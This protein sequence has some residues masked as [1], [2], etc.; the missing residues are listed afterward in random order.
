MGAKLRWRI[1]QIAVLVLI[2]AG[3]A[4][5]QSAGDQF[6]PDAPVPNLPEG[7]GSPRSSSGDA[8]PSPLPVSSRLSAHQKYALAFRR[9][10][11]PQMPLRAAFVSGW[12]LGTDTGP[13]MPTNGWGPFVERFGYNAAAIS[14]TIFFSTAFVPAIVHQDPR[15]FRMGRGRVKSRIWWAVRSE[16]V[17]VGDDGH[18][19][20]NYAN[21]LGFALSSAAI[22]TFT[23]RDSAGFGDTVERYAIKI[24]VSTGLNVAREFTAFD[25]AKDLLRHSKIYH[26]AR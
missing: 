20:P 16:I 5:A 15:Y 10:V 4:V 3:N 2:S 8:R 13:D 17:G 24:G 14:T 19:M 6:L 22:D 25:H 11:S 26:P 7:H 23:P 1:G 21:L 9:I 18:S 12:E